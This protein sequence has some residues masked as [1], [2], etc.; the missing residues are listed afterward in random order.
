[1]SQSTISHRYFMVFD[2]IMDRDN[3]GFNPWGMSA[4]VGGAVLVFIGYG[5]L[6]ALYPTYPHL[7]ILIAGIGCIIGGVVIAIIS[8]KKL[9]KGDP[10]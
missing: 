7:R 9:L 2:G 8:V 10:L 3:M 4:I 6:T 1:M 5:I